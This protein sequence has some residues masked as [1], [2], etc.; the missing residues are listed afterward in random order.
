MSAKEYSGKQALWLPN[1]MPSRKELFDCIKD[2]VAIAQPRRVK[3]LLKFDQLCTGN[4]LRQ[5][6]GMPDFDHGIARSM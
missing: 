1:S 4:V 5:V 6:A 2:G 3:W